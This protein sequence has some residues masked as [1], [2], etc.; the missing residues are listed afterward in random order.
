MQFIPYD[1]HDFTNE[2]DFSEWLEVDSLKM[3]KV[4]SVDAAG[5]SPEEIADIRYVLSYSNTSAKQGFLSPVPI[6]ITDNAISL[7]LSGQTP[8]NTPLNV[9]YGWIEKQL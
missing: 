8:S 5:I 1:T 7:S 9:A 2:L 6:D 4:F 3:L